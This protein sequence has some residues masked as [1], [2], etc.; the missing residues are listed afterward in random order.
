MDQ[1][2]ALPVSGDAF[3]LRRANRLILVDGGRSSALLS[4]ELTKYGV[5]HLDVVICTH[6]DH[7]HAGGL[8]DLLDRSKIT[9]GEFWLPGAWAE[10]LPALLETPAIVVDDLIQTLDEGIHGVSL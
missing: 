10:S 6:A 2:I 8:V 7:D 9:V 1:L 5:N 4:K 3:L